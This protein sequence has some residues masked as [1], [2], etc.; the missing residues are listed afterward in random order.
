MKKV[1][2]EEASFPSPSAKVKIN[3]TIGKYKLLSAGQKWKEHID[4]INFALADLLI[5]RGEQKDYKE[6]LGYYN[7][8]ISTSKNSQLKGRSMIGKAELS[9]MGIVKIGIDDAVKLC[10]NGCKLLKGDLKDFFV[11]KGIAVEAELLV[12]KSG[13]RNVKQAAGLFDKLINKK[14][15]NPYFRGR[16]MV[17]K[18]ELI[19]YFKLDSLSTG[20][21]L[22]EESLKIFSDRPIDYFAIKAKVIEAEM[23]S[24]RGSPSDIAKAENL[25][26]KVITTSGSHKDLQARAKLVLAETSGQE[27]KA[28]Q[29]FEEVVSQED[30][31]PYLIEKAKVIAASMKNRIN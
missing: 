6:A 10:K 25:C 24:R 13:S 15:A 21:K 19:L 20:I 28:Q 7:S 29:L 8:I 14:N 2:D 31:D 4:D 17:G 3:K 23:L 18:A 9:I 11:A 30:I 5:S 27:K 1:V 26:K 12:K 22:C 16:A